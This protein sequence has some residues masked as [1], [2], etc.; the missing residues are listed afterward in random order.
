VAN[1]TLGYRLPK[2]NRKQGAA[3][4]GQLQK[5]GIYRESGHEHFSG[6]LIIPVMNEQHNVVEVYGRKL[7]DT[8]RKGTPKH[9][10]L[11]GPHQGVFNEQALQAST[12]LILCESLID[13][14]TFWSHGYRNVTSSYGTSGFTDEHL[15]AL[16]QNNI[17]RVLIEMKPERQPHK[18]YPNN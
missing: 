2:A 4:R 10:Y 5:I 6:S 7:L 16:Q 14:L 18:N 3:L 15:S 1:R 8:L 11:P 13:A 12:E 17:K 9:L